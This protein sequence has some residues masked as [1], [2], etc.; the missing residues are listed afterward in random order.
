VSPDTYSPQPHVKELSFLSPWLLRG[1]RRL[2]RPYVFSRTEGKCLA[3]ARAAKVAQHEW[4]IGGGGG[5]RD[6]PVHGPESGR[7]WAPTSEA[8]DSA[9]WCEVGTWELD[10][11]QGP[12][13]AASVVV[14]VVNP[15][16]D[17]AAAFHHEL[18]P[19]VSASVGEGRGEVGS[20]ASPAREAVT[21]LPT[22]EDT[23]T[24]PDG[25]ADGAAAD[26]AAADG[27]AADGA[28]DGTS[29][30]VVTLL[31]WPGSYPIETAG[32][33]PPPSPP[34][35]TP[36]PIQTGGSVGGSVTGDVVWAVREGALAGRLPP[37][38]AVVFTVSPAPAAGGGTQKVVKARPLRTG[39]GTAVPM[40]GKV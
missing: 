34:P 37:L 31:A 27:A 24:A 1:V 29:D 21:P 16:P 23:E 13:A 11:G 7:A 17:T 35:P 33:V 5:D 3:P 8:A 12:A 6:G 28:A 2:Q 20:G 9:S 25:A 40:R 22:R 26:G 10:E 4:G 14:V 36:T 32:S 30:W 19:G 38:T 18:G 39:L 15:S